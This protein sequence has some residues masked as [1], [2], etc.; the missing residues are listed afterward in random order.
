[1]KRLATLT[2]SILL[3]AFATAQTVTIKKG[4]VTVND[5]LYCKVTGKT[6]LLAAMENEFSVLTLDGKERIFIKHPSITGNCTLIFLDSGA[7][8]QVPGPATGLGVKPYII[9]LLW[10]NRVLEPAGL[11]TEGKRQLLFKYG[12]QPTAPQ[13]VSDT[14]Y[15]AARRNRAAPIFITGNSIEQDGVVIGT[16]NAE[17][18]TSDGKMFTVYTFSLPGGKAAAEFTVETF[19]AENNWLFLIRNNRTITV[20]GFSGP[21]AGQKF[22]L[23]KKAAALLVN[24]GCL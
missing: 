6:G 15:T 21:E 23:V 20:Y 3:F 9:R 24:N 12:W 1:M 14:G 7:A 17:T 18:K 4:Q 2:G 13:P 8:V 16:Y 10:N 22:D 19:A 11:N 5:S